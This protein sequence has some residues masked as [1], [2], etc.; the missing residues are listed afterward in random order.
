MRPIG[1]EQNSFRYPLNIILGTEAQV[2]LLRVMIRDVNGPISAADAAERAGLTSLGARKALKRLIEAGF[3]TTVGGGRKKQ[4]EISGN[5]ILVKAVAALFSAESERFE[6][7]LAS[8]R[9]SIERVEAHPLSAWI[10]SL[11]AHPGE[12]VKVCILQDAGLLNAT[13]KDLRSSLLELEAELDMTIELAGYTKADSP[14]QGP[15]SLHLYGLPASWDDSDAVGIMN[16]PPAH[17]DQ[18]LRLAGI[19]RIIGEIINED[20][21]VI[22]R[23]KR[24]T[25]KIM[26]RQTDSSTGDIEEWLNILRTYSV[27]RLVQFLTSDSERAVRLRQSCPL[28][29]VLNE[30]ERKRIYGEL[31]VKR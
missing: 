27:R 11:P 14:E 9:K 4:Y 22:E 10:P 7:I 20:R 15:E 18:D 5:D 30:K 19:C 29:A 23:A 21:S 16:V 2:R 25:Q 31:E 26:N 8:I 17:A 13:M 24:Y 3:V 1:I 6:H 28:F 12:P